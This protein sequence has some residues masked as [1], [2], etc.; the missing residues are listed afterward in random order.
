MARQ[1]FNLITVPANTLD[2]T[3]YYRAI[4]P[5]AHLRI[6]RQSL[7][8]QCYEKIF[9]CELAM[10]DAV[11]MQRPFAQPHLQIAERARLHGMPLWIDHDDNLFDVPAD[12]PCRETFM[13]KETHERIRKIFSLANIVSFSV[14]K[15][16][17]AYAP[18]LEGKTVVTIPNALMTNVSGKIPH[19]D[20]EK[21]PDL[22][23]WRGSDTH[24]K[25]LDAFTPEMIAASQAMP[26]YRWI[27]QGYCTYQLQD[28][29]GQRAERRKPVDIVDYH[30]IL[31]RMGPRIVVVPLSD[32][33]FNH[34]KSNIAWIEATFAGGVC[35]APDW[36]EWRRPG[37]VNYKDRDDFFAKLIDL[38]SW[39]D[40]QI[41]AQWKLSR[42]YV[43]KHLTIKSTNAQRSAIIDELEELAGD[44]EWRLAR[45]QTLYDDAVAS[46][47]DARKVK[48]A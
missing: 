20:G 34:G 11:F 33:V 29:I 26:Q 45:R 47:A 25:D 10:A 24:Q 23:L 16:A 5:M 35:L 7:Q 1:K 27:F 38:M 6:V 18:L 19:H 43:E 28:G 30:A 37:V 21:R 13:N 8:T 31:A 41:D 14:P 42:D 39:N 2:A 46:L 32:S 12:N 4:G 40:A 3:S 48:A 15:L 22:I 44:E 36:D 9:W 17:A